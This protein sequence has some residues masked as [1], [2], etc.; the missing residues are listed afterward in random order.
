MPDTFLDE[1]HFAAPVFG[2][3]EKIENLPRRVV[4]EI[5]FTAAGS[6]DVGPIGEGMRLDAVL[7]QVLFPL[8]QIEVVRAVFEDAQAMRDLRARGADADVEAE[9]AHAVGDEVFDQQD[10]LVGVENTLDLLR[11]AV[12]FGLLTDVD[13]R[14]AELLRDERGVGDSRGLAAGDDVD[15]LA[16]DRGFGLARH[17]GDDRFALLG[18]REEPAAVDVDRRYQSEEHTSELQSHSFISYAV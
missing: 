3:F 13:H 18:E 11:A 16:A 10:A 8:M 7:G 9:L 2:V 15:R 17:L 14:L 12:A 4:A 1:S 5:F 6:Q